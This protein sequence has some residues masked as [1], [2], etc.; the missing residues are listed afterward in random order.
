MVVRRPTAPSS[1]ILFHAPQVLLSV[2][3]TSRHAPA[4][5]RSPGV[6]H[7]AGKAGLDSRQCIRFN[8]P[9]S[10]KSLLYTILR[11]PQDV[12]P[13]NPGTCS[14]DGVPQDS[15]A[16]LDAWLPRHP[17]GMFPPASAPHSH[18]LSLSILIGRL[19]I[20]DHSEVGRKFQSHE[21]SAVPK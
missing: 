9:D 21:D 7:N 15:E 14:A 6:A 2:S 17:K 1:L 5:S 12:V 3:Q 8:E 19:G 4:P 16:A 20:Q 13:K 11:L 18:T 10:P